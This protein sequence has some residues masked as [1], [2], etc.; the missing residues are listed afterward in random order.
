MKEQ[1]LEAFRDLGFKL[2]EDEG[3]GYCFNYEGLN[4]LY[5]YNEND[6]EFLN[7]ALPGI[8]D[9]EEDN[10]LQ[11]CALLEKINS[12]LKYIKAYILGNSVWLFYERELIVSREQMGEGQLCGEEDLMTVISRMILHLEAGFVFARKAMAE[13]EE[14]MAN[15]S[16]DDDT[17][18]SA[19]E[20]DA[21]EIADDEDNE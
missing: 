13:L 9:V 1:I 20:I 17:A 19:E 18:E 14:T 2:E 21:E 11:I 5:M 15:D 10:M 3:M 12:T 6:D 8:V 16:S 7:I 4:L